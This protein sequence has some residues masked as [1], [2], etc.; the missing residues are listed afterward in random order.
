MCLLSPS[1]LHQLPSCPQNHNGHRPRLLS[2]SSPV[3]HDLQPKLGQDCSASP[4]SCSFLHQLCRSADCSPHQ[5]SSRHL[6]TGNVCASPPHS[7]F[8]HHHDCRIQCTWTH[9][10]TKRVQA[11]HRAH[12]T[13]A[14]QRSCQSLQMHPQHKKETHLLLL[15]GDGPYPPGG[16]GI[17]MLT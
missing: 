15:Q 13:A 16:G 3:P 14:R 6:S 9:L 12:S 1:F 17:G 4:L 11:Q 5:D 2:S 8:L 7:R 10:Q